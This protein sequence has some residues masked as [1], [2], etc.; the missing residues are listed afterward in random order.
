M[1]RRSV[2][3]REQR[4]GLRV[5][6][7]GVRGDVVEVGHGEHQP[8]AARERHARPVG[9]PLHAELQALRVGGRERRLDQQAVAVLRP[10]GP[11]ADRLVPALARRAEQ[12]VLLQRVDDLLEADEVGLERR[13]VREQERQPLLPAIGEVED[14]QG[15]DEQAVQR[16][17]RSG[18]GQDR[19]AGRAGRRSRSATRRAAVRSGEGGRLPQLEQE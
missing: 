12:P 10:A 5:T 16:G 2:Q 9:G 1:R 8:R 17:L 19:V 4:G 15:R 18:L 3:P 11:A 7:S 14:V 13:H 6:G